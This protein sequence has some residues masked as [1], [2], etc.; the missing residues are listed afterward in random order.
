MIVYKVRVT[1]KNKVEDEWFLWMATK[2]IPGV[3]NTGH[4]V[5]YAFMKQLLNGEIGRDHATYEIQYFCRTQAD[6]D[7]Y[8]SHNAEKL[9]KDYSLKYGNFTK[10]IN[11][12]QFEDVTE[13]MLYLV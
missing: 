9:R 7:T 8:L 2:H 4:F 5:D 11:R 10:E 6:L 13:K 12:S 1:I 3:I